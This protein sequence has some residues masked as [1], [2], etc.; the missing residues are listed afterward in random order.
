MFKEIALSNQWREGENWFD[1]VIDRKF[2]YTGA[3]TPTPSDV[4]TLASHYID[5]TVSQEEH[6]KTR[7]V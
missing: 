3:Q 7:D 2:G 1:H 5:F 6:S 4:Q